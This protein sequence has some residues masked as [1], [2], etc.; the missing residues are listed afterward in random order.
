MYKVTDGGDYMEFASAAEAAHAIRHW[1]EYLWKQ[2]PE[3]EAAEMPDMPDFPAWDGQGDL[4][5]YAA[6]ITHIARAALPAASI[7]AVRVEAVD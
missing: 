5:D 3:E 2:A 4:A 1:Y 7:E 6:L